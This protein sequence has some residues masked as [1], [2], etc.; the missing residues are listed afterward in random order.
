MTPPDEPPESAH[1]ADPRAE[2]LGFWRGVA[3]YCLFSLPLWALAG[4]AAW[5]VFKG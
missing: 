1:I 2:F 4:A 5:W 3:N